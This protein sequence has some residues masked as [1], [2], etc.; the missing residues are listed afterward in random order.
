MHGYKVF[1]DTKILISILELKVSLIRAFPRSLNCL[2]RR[3]KCRLYR[4][5][6]ALVRAGRSSIFIF[7]LELG[8]RKYSNFKVTIFKILLL[9]QCNTPL[10]FFGELNFIFKCYV[11]SDRYFLTSR[12]TP[13]KSIGLEVAIT[14]GLLV[15]V[16]PEGSK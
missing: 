5:P 14:F 8:C 4:Y 16:K 12:L 10:I 7:F 11:R 13:H 6:R 9:L 3:Y 15:E 2:K 1:N